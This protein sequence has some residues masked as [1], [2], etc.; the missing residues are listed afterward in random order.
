MQ[1]IVENCVICLTSDLKKTFSSTQNS[2]IFSKLK[3]GRILSNGGKLN[4]GAFEPLRNTDKDTLYVKFRTKNSVDFFLKQFTLP[5][6]L[7]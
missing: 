3:K 2:N 1:G 7:Y 6:Y 5:K 4:K